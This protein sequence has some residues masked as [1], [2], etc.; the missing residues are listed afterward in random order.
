MINRWWGQTVVGFDALRQSR[1]L[2]PFGIEH[3]TAQMLGIALAVVV[4]L[5]LG[6]G[7][8]LASLRPRNKPRD[9]LAAAHARLQRKLA[10][11]GIVRGHAEGPRDFYTRSASSLPDSAPHL[12]ELAD[13]YL[14]LRYA[15]S[16]PPPQRTHA[17]FQ[18]VR[19]FHP[20]PP[21]KRRMV[22][23]NSHR[24]RGWQP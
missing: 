18:R 24:K 6:A 19:R 22:N 2:R 7:A 4:F 11:L 15:Y 8:L 14:L 5:A 1:L 13:E 3:A 21:P 10:R 9:A 20:R 17:F 12:R 23:A 16:E